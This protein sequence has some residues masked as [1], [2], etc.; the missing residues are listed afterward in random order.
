MLFTIC[1]LFVRKSG[2]SPQ[3]AV[4]FMP[5][6]GDSAVSMRFQLN[7]NSNRN[8]APG[9]DSTNITDAFN[10]LSKTNA[11][12]ASVNELD[13]VTIDYQGTYLNATDTQYKVVDGAQDIGNID[14]NWNSTISHYN[15][16]YS[17]LFS[18]NQT[19]LM[20]YIFLHPL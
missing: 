16:F 3:T 17:K 2:T 8:G 10:V 15:W 13:N 7:L 20:F 11:Y 9:T 5:D 18:M 14:R 4:Q 19:D 1:W 6:T 12:T